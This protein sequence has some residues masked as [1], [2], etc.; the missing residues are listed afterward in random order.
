MARAASRAGGLIRVER[1]EQLAPAIA[2]LLAE[3]AT[4]RAMGERA[5]RAAQAADAGLDRLWSHLTP[6]LPAGRGS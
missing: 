4:A 3:P 5:R 1:A 2:P 6:L